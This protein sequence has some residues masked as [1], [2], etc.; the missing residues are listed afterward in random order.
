STDR[1]PSAASS[2]ERPTEA[3][4]EP[5]PTTE[6]VLPSSEPLITRSVPAPEPFGARDAFGIRQRTTRRAASRW[7][8]PHTPHPPPPPHP[9]H[10]PHPSPLPHPRRPAASPGCW[11]PLF[12][13]RPSPRGCPPT[14]QMADDSLPGRGKGRARR[15]P[16]QTRAPPPAIRRAE[17]RTFS[18]G[19]TH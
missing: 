15:R 14:R 4:M 12:P 13:G 2:V 3:T 19:G 5:A 18:P 1:L 17:E 8:T 11:L 10:P 7:P 16:A 6:T 9:P